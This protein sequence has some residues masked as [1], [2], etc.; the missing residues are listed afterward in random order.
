MQ[1]QHGT[2]TADCYGPMHDPNYRIQLLGTRGDAAA[3]SLRDFLHRCD[4]PFEWLELTSDEQA[5]TLARA[6]G[7]NDP[8]LP[9]CIFPDGTRME[10]PSV[11]Q[12]T[13][14]LGWFRN[15][16]R[17]EYDLSI[18][19]A[20]P[21]GLS[22]AVYGASEGLKTVVVER[23]TVGGQAGPARKSKTIWASRKVSAEQS[24]PNEPAIR[25]ITSEQRFLSSEKAFGASSFLAGASVTWQMG[26]KSSRGL[27]SAPPASIIGA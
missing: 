16:S 10:R 18:Y 25:R 9:I 17:S 20:G 23:L 7:L 24:W 11:R 13:E 4:V 15:P 2:E 27:L 22:A 21:A 19:G 5:R 14:K 8:R 12:I 6:S 26:Q 1:L 3:Y